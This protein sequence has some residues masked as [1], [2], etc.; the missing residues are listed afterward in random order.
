MWQPLFVIASMMAGPP[1][2]AP[3]PTHALARF[4]SHRLHH[5]LGLRL[6][7]LSPDGRLIASA[8][9]STEI[10]LWDAATG[11]RLRVL[12][13][14]RAGVRSLSFSPEGHLATTDPEGAAVFDART[15]ERRAVHEGDLLWARFAS[16]G[17]LVL[18]GGEWAAGLAGASFKER[19]RSA[20]P[21]R[22]GERVS[23]A[24]L[25]TDGGRIAWLAWDTAG[26]MILFPGQ[27]EPP[28]NQF[29]TPLALVLAEARTGKVVFRREKQ[30]HHRG[31]PCLSAGGRVWFGHSELRDDKG[32]PVGKP[33]DAEM[34]WPLALAPDGKRMVGFCPP[35]NIDVFDTATGKRLRR[36][37]DDYPDLN[38]DC[39]AAH[40]RL[41]ADGSKLLLVARGRLRLIDARTGAEELPPRTRLQPSFSSDGKTLRAECDG[42]R[43]AWNLA[44]GLP[45]ASARRGRSSNG[46][47]RKRASPDGRL[48][49]LAEGQAVRVVEIATG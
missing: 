19:W 44:S 37:I 27:R 28:M 25:S 30:F 43:L 33:L 21:V 47:M 8:G 38:L 48:L 1:H 42:S 3:L 40:Q 23:Q 4:G 5:G 12:R 45:F 9:D 7:A 22:K 46:G 32:R 10:V 39:L 16:D 35:F 6:A 14:R 26:L 20:A 17:G 2:A 11:E 15:G 18:C 34:L 24:F 29:G 31:W 13:S 49:A 41:S 36:L